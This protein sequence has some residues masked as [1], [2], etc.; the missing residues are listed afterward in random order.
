M[1]PE[2]LKELD[3]AWESYEQM[4]A[5]RDMYKKAYESEKNEN[6]EMR[7][8]VE[9]WR[10]CYINERSKHE[11]VEGNQSGESKCRGKDTCACQGEKKCG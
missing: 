2:H 11:G 10:N 4:K 7:C 5:Q 6:Q 3:E 9:Y 1:K 8:E